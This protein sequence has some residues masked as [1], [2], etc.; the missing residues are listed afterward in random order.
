MPTDVAAVDR[1]IGIGLSSARRSAGMVGLVVWLVATTAAAESPPM[2]RFGVR[3]LQASVAEQP[4]PGSPSPAREAE[5]DAQLR[6]ILPRLR[7]VFRYSV[8]RTLVLEAVEGPLTGEQRFTLPGGAWLKVMPEM[9]E[10]NAVQMRVQFLRG[11]E[12]EL[13]SRIVSAPGAPVIFGGYPYGKGVLII[14][15]WANP[16]SRALALSPNR[17]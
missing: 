8:Y 15:L 13:S 2:I 3:V 14:I 1:E 7:A 11:T 16:D 9:V 17:R 10:H 6:R 5:P 12:V 4:P